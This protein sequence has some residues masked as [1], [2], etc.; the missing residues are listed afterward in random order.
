M[1]VTLFKLWESDCKISNP[2]SITLLHPDSHLATIFILEDAKRSLEEMYSKSIL[3]VPTKCVA[4]T[5]NFAVKCGVQFIDFE[6]R[7]DGKLLPQWHTLVNKEHNDDIT[8]KMSSFPDRLNPG[9]KRNAEICSSCCIV[10]ARLRS[11]WNGFHSG[12]SIFKLLQQL[13]PRRAILVRGSQQS[14]NSLRDFCSEVL[15]PTNRDGA[16]SFFPVQPLHGCFWCKRQADGNGKTRN[17][18]K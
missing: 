16:L 5:Q 6:G 17:L 3:Q 11:S 7:T 9:V 13:R 14:L 1:V 18:W 15:M 8:L 4:S 2:G 12:E 10:L